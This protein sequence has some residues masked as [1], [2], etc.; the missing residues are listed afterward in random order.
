MFLMSYG[1]VKN[2][3]SSRTEMICAKSRFRRVSSSFTSLGSS[4]VPQR[5]IQ[6]VEATDWT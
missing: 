5:G 3:A 6:K 4:W 2:F 1:G